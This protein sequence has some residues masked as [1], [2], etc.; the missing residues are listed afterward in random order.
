MDR[1]VRHAA[2]WLLDEIDSKWISSEYAR[3]V[4][5]P[6][7]AAIEWRDR[8]VRKM[9]ARRDDNRLIGPWATP[10]DDALVSSLTRILEQQAAMVS[11]EHLKSISSWKNILYSVGGYDD[12]CYRNYDVVL[13]RSRLRLLARQELTRRK[14]SGLEC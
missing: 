3:D 10:T 9:L 1:S 2:E 7:I 13:D 12:G 4:I 5:Q 6:L 8:L 11:L 14:H